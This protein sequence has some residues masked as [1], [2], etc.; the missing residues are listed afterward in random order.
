MKQMKT[1]TL[2]GTM[3]EVVDETSRKDIAN[4][5]ARIVGLSTKIN[6]QIDPAI[7][8]I[9]R[10]LGD[11]ITNPATGEIGHIL[12]VKSVDENGKPVVYETIENVKSTYEYAKLGG[13]TGSEEDFY[14]KLAQE[15]VTKEELNN[16]NTTLNN[17]LNTVDSKYETSINEIIARIETIEAKIDK[18]ENSEPNVV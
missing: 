16:V 2:G 18:E 7:N 13:Y 10:S 4:L 8:G 11:K 1:L 12:T 5:D 17:Q 9:N 3:Y 15:N 6:N 14:K